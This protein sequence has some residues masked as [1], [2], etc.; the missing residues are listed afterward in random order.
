MGDLPHLAD[1]IA[2]YHAALFSPSL[3]TW[4]TAINNGH[5]TSWPELTSAQV[6]KHPPQSAAMIKGHMDQDRQNI[7]STKH[8]KITPDDS[9][10]TPLKIEQEEV[11][12]NPIPP[13]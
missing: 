2:F 9:I 11:T 13:L 12:S 8:S 4:C 3:S 7:R 6:C 10:S 5:M 1:R